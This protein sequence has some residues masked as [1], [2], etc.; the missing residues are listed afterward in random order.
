MQTI[1]DTATDA[2]KFTTLL[3]ALTAASLTDTLRTAGPY[4][5]FAPTD[6]A[7]QRLA[8]GALDA[9]LNDT[10]RLYTVLAYHVVPGI[11]TAKDV[12]PGN[13]MTIAGT[14]LVASR[15]GGEIF[16]NGA[17]IMRADIPA[18]NGVVHMIDA[19]IMPLGTMLAA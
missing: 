9:L 12:T 8:P 10:N 3:S 7:F 16:L 14:S 2:G 17:K 15:H 5:L 1:I 18:S 4:T 13:I 11:I 6:E 19:V